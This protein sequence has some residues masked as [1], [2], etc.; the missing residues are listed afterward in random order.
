MKTKHVKTFCAPHRKPVT[1]IPCY[2]HVSGQME[3]ML[4]RSSK[5]LEACMPKKT[6]SS[7]QKIAAQEEADRYLTEAGEAAFKEKMYCMQ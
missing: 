2:R 1:N 5:H 7:D 3:D 4:G 6:W